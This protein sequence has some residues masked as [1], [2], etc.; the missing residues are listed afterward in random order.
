MTRPVA[1]AGWSPSYNALLYNLPVQSGPYEDYREEVVGSLAGRMD[2]DEYTVEKVFFASMPGHY[3]SGN[4][5]RPKGKEGKH[6]AVLC[7]HGHWNEGRQMWTGDKAA[8]K[9]VDIG[10]EK[11]IEGARS[12]LQ[13]RCAMLARRSSPRAS[14]GPPT[15]T[16]APQ[17]RRSICSSSTRSACHRESLADRASKRFSPTPSTPPR[18]RI[19]RGCR[20]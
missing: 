3:V 19:T 14:C 16:S 5:Y 6:P 1:R 13:A 15:A 9:Q 4:L 2:R 18:T 11:T 17:E 10:A 7:P 20:G 12:P 8:Q